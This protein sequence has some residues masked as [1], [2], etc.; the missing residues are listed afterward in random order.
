MFQI[1]NQ[2]T[3]L[4]PF[5]PFTTVPFVDQQTTLGPFITFNPFT[6]VPFVELIPVLNSGSI[7]TLDTCLVV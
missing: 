7:S 5:N 1:D 3:T 2:Q 6:T 4:G